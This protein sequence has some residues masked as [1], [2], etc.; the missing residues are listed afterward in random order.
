M[1]QGVGDFLWQAEGVVGG[2]AIALVSV[3]FCQGVALGVA[4][5]AGGG[6]GG[7]CAGGG[8]VGGIGAAG[9]AGVTLGSGEYPVPPPSP[10]PHYADSY[11]FESGLTGGH[12]GFV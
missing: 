12:G 3:V 2:V 8:S 5:V 4:G 7:A 11:G 1:A 10:C 6:G 9:D